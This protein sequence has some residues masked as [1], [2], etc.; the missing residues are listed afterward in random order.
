MEQRALGSTS[1]RVGAVG[2]GVMPLAIQN[3][4][5]EADAVRVI[6]TALDQGVNFFDTADCYCHD[7][8][9]VGYGERLLAKAL[10]SYGGARDG[11]VFATKGGY[12]RPGGAWQVSGRPE[13]LRAACEASLRALGVSSIPLYFLHGPDPAVYYPDAVG[14]LWKLKQEGKIQHIGLSNVDVGHIEE[15]LAITPVAAVQNRSNVFERY[16]YA[17]G[18]IDLCERRGIAFVAHSAVGGHQGHKQAASNGALARIAARHGVSNYQVALAW[19]LASSKSVLAIP[20]AS[21]PASIV[22][23]VAAAQL[24]LSDAD[25]AELRAAFPLAGALKKQFVDMRRRVRQLA[26]NFRAQHKA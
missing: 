24:V 20:G 4:P 22:S 1:W 5:S 14:A 8:H 23:S 21:R 16:N 11:V 9:D 2:L 7:E 10:T 19:L 15:A 25:H 12:V 13:R 3:R 18:V 6:H 17:N 26:R